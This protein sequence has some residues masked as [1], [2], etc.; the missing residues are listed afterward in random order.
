MKEKYNIRPRNIIIAVVVITMLG[1]LFSFWHISSEKKEVVVV[2]EEGKYYI[3]DN[4]YQVNKKIFSKQLG[5]IFKD[6]AGI[7]KEVAFEYESYK[8]NKKERRLTIEI[9]KDMKNFFNKTTINYT[10]IKK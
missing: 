10:F 4:G 8:Y 7:K 1:L 3:S 6:K 2:T 9:D 5:I